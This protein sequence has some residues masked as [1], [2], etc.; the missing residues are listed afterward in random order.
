MGVLI[1]S[2]EVLFSV[3]PNTHKF[4]RR[5]FERSVGQFFRIANDPDGGSL[6]NLPRGKRSRGFR[7]NPWAFAKECDCFVKFNEKV[8]VGDLQ[9]LNEELCIAV[10]R[11]RHSTGLKSVD[12]SQF[13][14]IAGHDVS[15]ILRYLRDPQRPAIIPRYEIILPDPEEVDRLFAPKPKPQ[16]KPPPEPYRGPELEVREV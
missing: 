8:Y 4:V 3:E 1:S 2:R 14:R 5:T 6:A 7:P 16:P 9:S 10:V 13:E 11:L 15:D 12:F